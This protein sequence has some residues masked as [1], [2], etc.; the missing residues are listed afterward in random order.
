MQFVL[1]LF[2]FTGCV[3]VGLRT[4]GNADD[5]LI[6]EGHCSRR[7]TG[8]LLRDFNVRETI[9][10]TRRRYGLGVVAH[11]VATEAVA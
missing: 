5:G 9:F 10:G 11:A 7:A 2:L 4:S 3:R 8:R 6:V 1:R